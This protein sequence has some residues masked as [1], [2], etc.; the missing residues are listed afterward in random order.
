MTWFQR[1]VETYDACVD[2]P[3][4]ASAPIPPISHTPQQ[5]HIEIV[6]DSAGHFKRARLVQKEETVIPATEQSAGR[7]SQPAPHP[8]CDKVQYVAADYRDYGGTKPSFHKEYIELLSA[9]CESPFAH[10]KAK[11]VLDY[12]KRGTVVADLVS[13]QVLSVGTDGKLLTDWRDLPEKPDIFKLL[14]GSAGD[15]DQGGALVR[16]LI[17]G[18][19]ELD[20]AVWRDKGLQSSWVAYNASTMS[21]RGLCMASGET[22]AALTKSHPKRLRHAA[23]GA[24]LVSSNDN[25]G[26]TFRGRFTDSTGD[27]ACGVGF[28]SSQKAHLALRWLIGRQSYRHSEQVIVAWALR[29]E[30]VP[31][32]F[33]DTFE[34]LELDAEP[35]AE[36][37]ANSYRGDAGQ[38]YALEL[39]KKIAGYRSGFGPD[40]NVV[41][42]AVEAATPGRMAVTFYREFTGSEFL[43]RIESWH[44]R[45]A[46]PQNLGKARRFVGAPSPSDI[47]LAAYGP[48]VDDKL[49]TA[50]IER[51][52]PCILEQRR[53]PRD[54]MESAVRRAARRNGLEPFDWERTLGVACSLYKAYNY[55]RDYK[56]ALDDERTSR[57]YLYGRLLA[58]ADRIEGYALRLANENRETTAS[59][60]M[61]R[62]ADHPYSTWRTI[63]M[64]LVPYEA[65]IGS[66]SP[67]TLSWFRQ[68]LDAINCLFASEDY[69]NDKRL[70]G[71]FLLGYHCQRA[72]F[73][74]HRDGHGIEKTKGED[75]QK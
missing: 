48:R 18:D 35:A 59:R 11:S 25:G 53:V 27:Q 13:S 21:R 73:F 22:D 9:W 54:M 49:R 10:P 67:A 14:T 29:G 64:S 61:Q 41:I 46:W 43:E 36:P 31:S 16:W 1:L 58:V 63:E 39:R 60:L 33:I 75:T 56:M 51:L 44:Q 74:E 23:D 26:F 20:P 70:S 71:E 24:K 72:K 28:I 3:Q 19:G 47:A 66:R 55:E 52:L 62:F 37:E 69:T 7:T 38:R 6:L 40:T 34:L 50:C 45:M 65:R 5:A 68:Q 2:A 15:Q 4:F 17:E 42:L 8:L 30:P 12:V 57:D 32:P